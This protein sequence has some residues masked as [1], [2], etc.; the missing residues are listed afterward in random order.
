MST[1]G[2]PGEI[3]PVPPDLTPETFDRA[4]GIT[5]ASALFWE[6]SAKAF[7]DDYPVEVQPFG[8]TTWWVLGRWVSELRV[9]PGQRLVDL[10]CGR[11]GPGL[12][13]AR[14][15]GADLTGIDWSPVAVREATKRA[16]AFVQPGRAHFHVGQ[17]DATG[18][19]PEYAD[20]A[21]CAD[22]IF[23]AEDRV[24]AFAEV[25]RV[26]RPGAAFVF[27]CDEEDSDR[28]SAVPDWAPLADAGGLT[29]ERK[30]EVPRAVEN[31]QRMYD[32]WLANID[33]LRAE[34]G[35]DGANDLVDEATTVGPTLPM[36]RSLVITA[37]KP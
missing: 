11:G 22:A 25:A 20:A 15:T 14:A 9:G 36:R 29:V 12:W 35:A 19:P 1:E 26:L 21:M 23:F 32:L 33:A 37:R 34:I 6:L 2:L 10:A 16:A 24:A 13:V 8:T 3:A 31:M 4:H 30:D 7:G 17:L 27:T 5:A 28:P 18:L